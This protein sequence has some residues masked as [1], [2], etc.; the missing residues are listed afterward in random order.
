MS[1]HGRRILLAATGLTPQVVTE[2]LY[3]LAV[4]SEEKWF[5]TEI[6]VVTTGEGAE[7]AKLTL[8]DR[9][10]GWVGRLGREYGLPP[11]HFTEE[12]IEVL[13]GQ[14]GEPLADIRSADDSAVAADALTEVV[15]RMTADRAASV[16]VSIAGGRKT[17]GFLLGYALS[18]Y[19]RPQDR[20]SHVLVD[21]RFE[22]HPEFFFPSREGRIIYT[23]PP[24]S[25][26]LDTSKAR[27]T[28]AEI[29]F[30]RLRG[31]LRQ[32]ERSEPKGF[33]QAVREAQAGVSAELEFDLRAGEVRAGGVTVAMAPAELAFY[34][35]MAR[36]AH[37]GLPAVGCPGEGPDP[38]LGMA[39][40]AEY[41]QVAS[42]G[43]ALR[44]RKALRGGMDR[45]FFLQRRAR[46]EAALRRGMGGDAAAYLI[47]REGSRP[48]S[49]YRLRVR[50]ECV[51]FVDR[52]S[53][54]TTR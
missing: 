45:T 16:H 19:G 30:V 44:T 49:T 6:R 25:R 46:V 50:G 20:L 34:A 5:P 2:T 42:E 7:R 12:S 1:K 3:A 41:E 29:P 11:V 4:S 10:A 9:G 48:H 54:G 32:D 24:A 52:R 53:E 13:R 21:A 35:M 18:L 15:R 28:L 36:R 40:L 31:L 23:A 14:D 43:E 17:M 47:A 26:P 37:G 51:G 39:F 8:L 38:V 22:S 27:V 33:E